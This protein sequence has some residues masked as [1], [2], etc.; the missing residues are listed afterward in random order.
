MSFFSPAWGRRLLF[1]QTETLLCLQESMKILSCQPR[2][3]LAEG[4]FP[5]VCSGVLPLVCVP[6]SGFKYPIHILP[7][8]EAST[9]AT[10]LLRRRLPNE[11]RW[12]SSFLSGSGTEGS[13]ESSGTKD[14]GE[15]CC[16]N[17]VKQKANLGPRGGVTTKPSYRS[18]VRGRPWSVANR[19]PRR[20]GPGWMSFHIVSNIAAPHPLPST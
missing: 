3:W 13:L 8:S 4:L 20:K 7:A 19:R 18:Q 12:P 11:H 17:G 6:A 5:L 10:C 14:L 15:E 1:L 16:K 2:H 9:T